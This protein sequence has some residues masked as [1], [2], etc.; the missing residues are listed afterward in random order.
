M[1]KTIIEKYK[2]IIYFKKMEDSLID[3]YIDDDKNRTFMIECPKSIKYLELQN[4]LKEKNILRPDITNYNIIFGEKTYNNGK[5]NEILN[6]NNNDKII[7]IN[8]TKKKQF[9]NQ[10]NDLIPVISNINNEYTK[11]IP[12]SGFLRFNLIKYISN[13]ININLIKSKEIR[14]IISEL[15]KMNINLGNA[16]KGPEEDII[17]RLKDKTGNNFISY[18]RYV[19]SMLSNQD[20][21]NL[22]E[23]VEHD[24]KNNIIQQI[25]ILSKYEEINKN[26]EKSLEES[27]KNSY[28]D[29]S[30]INFVMFP[31]SDLNNYL[32]SMSKC[33]NLVKRYLFHGTHIESISKILTISFSFAKRAFYGFGIGFSDMLD[34]ISFY[35]GGDS[36][37]SKRSLYGKTLPVNSTFS[38]VGVEVYYSKDKIKYVFDNGHN[39]DKLKEE[40][41][42]NII[43]KNVSKNG[44]YITSNKEEIIKGQKEG[45]F[46]VSDYII[47]E[48][49]Q[50]LPLYGLTFKRNEYFVLWRDPNFNGENIHSD[51]LKIRQLFIYKYTKMNAYFESSTEKALEIIK[52]K[53]FNKIIL[54][55]SIG[56]DLSGKKFV[57]IARKILGFNVV[58]LFFSQNQ[59][60]FSWLQS[61]PNALYTNDNNFYKEYI[62][63]YNYEGLINLKKKIQNYYGINLYFTE[64]FF[65]FPKFI[66][67]KEYK[68]IIFNEPCPYFR[69]VV[70]KLLNDNSILYMNQNAC[71][72]LISPSYIDNLHYWYI[73]MMGNEITFYSNGRYLGVDLKKGMLISD[74]FM[75]RF[76]YSKVDEN[77]DEY[78]FFYENNNNILTAIGNNVRF[79]KY[80]GINQIF[81]LI[82][83]Y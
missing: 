67:Q 44:V 15:T 78:V 65:E 25:N 11:T 68:E 8:N 47:T 49:N 63:N 13:F 57:E 1:I 40:L 3:I 7:I 5:Q 75:Q 21:N 30:L 34:Y 58:V 59:K 36:L 28:F 64:D 2:N 66:N 18:S 83:N 20:I 14:E 4:I 43:N 37:E 50:I 26:F 16:P 71:P 70:I 29:Y 73:T 19:C 10:A 9:I 77:N 52:R 32:K 24:M 55:S 22:L 79:Q 33:H 42:T 23:L 48:N 76:I 51:I 54:I 81:K 38:C 53:K 12:L 69:K 45:K 62:L 6:F 72:S 17:L 74:Q 27:I 31:Q 46:I 39:V 60:H 61:F 41:K 82:E 35:H 56:L 80:T